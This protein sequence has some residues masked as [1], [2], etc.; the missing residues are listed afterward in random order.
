M[1]DYVELEGTDKQVS[2]FGKMEIVAALAVKVQREFLDEVDRDKKF[3]F[4]Y[5]FKEF[6]KNA[7]PYILY[8]EWNMRNDILD[9]SI[10]YILAIKT[11]DVNKISKEA[12]NIIVHRTQN[13]HTSAVS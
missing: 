5:V 2:F 9:I 3:S 4:G 12:M 10:P 13:I 11:N 1:K 6:D 8:I 7:K